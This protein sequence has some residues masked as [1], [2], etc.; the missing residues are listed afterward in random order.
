MKMQLVTELSIEMIHFQIMLSN[1]GYSNFKRLVVF[2]SRKEQ[3]NVSRIQEAFPEAHS[4]QINEL[5]CKKLEGC[6]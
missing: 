2:Y 5:L 4:N 1:I 3:E 6:S